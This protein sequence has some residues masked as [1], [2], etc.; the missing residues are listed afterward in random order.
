M[1]EC[2]GSWYTADEIKRW[3]DREGWPD[4]NHEDEF[5]AWVAKHF[6]LALEKGWQLR[7]NSDEAEIASLCTQL[8]NLQEENDIW[9]KHALVQIV[10]ERDSLRSQL[11]DTQALLTPEVRRAAEYLAKNVEGHPHTCCLKCAAH[12]AG[13]EG[14]IRKCQELR[15]GIED[16][17]R[18]KTVY[19]CDSCLKASL[20]LG[21]A[22]SPVRP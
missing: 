2:P 21:N 5:P 17:L 4:G 6:Q 9:E 3:L 19:A 22:L 20:I 7:T 12:I 11:Q 16:K 15:I 10:K 14:A 1:S 13:L 18:G 8:A